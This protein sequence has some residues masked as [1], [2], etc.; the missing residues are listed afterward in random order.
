MTPLLLSL[1]S[2]EPETPKAKAQDPTP[3]LIV[4]IITV[5]VIIIV[6]A[7]KIIIDIIINIL[8]VI[9][10]ILILLCP[11]YGVEKVPAI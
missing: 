9:L 1:N 4:S 5:I 7:I 10:I 11:L 6:I 3:P 2:T 8:I